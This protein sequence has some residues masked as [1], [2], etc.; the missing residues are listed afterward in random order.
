MQ[1]TMSQNLCLPSQNQSRPK[2]RI[3]VDIASIMIPPTIFHQQTSHRVIYTLTLLHVHRLQREEHP[4]SQQV[5]PATLT[6]HL[7]L[8]PLTVFIRAS[9]SS[10]IWPCWSC[11]WK[12]A[13]KRQ[14]SSSVHLFVCIKKHHLATSQTAGL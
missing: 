4:E 3:F 10:Q 2:V 5:F 6:S 1:C 14:K 11:Y 8:L 9:V 12:T 13:E 7:L